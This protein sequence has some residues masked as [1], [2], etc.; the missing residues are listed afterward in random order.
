MM[1]RILNG[2]DFMR[3]FR[4]ALGL[5]IV[6]QSIVVKDWTLAFFGSLF[7]LMPVLNIGCCGAAGCSVPVKKH[8]KETQ[9]IS[10]EEVR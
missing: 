9:D 6:V 7:V 4:L 5:L 2:W 10:Y 8:G 1:N 3:A